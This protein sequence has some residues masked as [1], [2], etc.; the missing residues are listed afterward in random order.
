VEV[1]EDL[2][3]G[4]DGGL[5]VGAGIACCTRG[6][7]AGRSGGFGLLHDEGGVLDVF[8]C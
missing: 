5:D 4:P 6:Q 2:G 7:F 8:Y 3:P 1:A